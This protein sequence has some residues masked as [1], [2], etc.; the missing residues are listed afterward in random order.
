[1]ARELASWGRYPYIPQQRHPCSWRND[2]SSLLQRLA[3]HPQGTLPYGN[4]RSYGDSCLAVSGELLQTRQL[5]RFLSAD[6][7]Q[8]VIR[9]EAGVTLAEVLEVAI[10][11]GWFLPVTP[12]TKFVTLGGA[13]ANDVH[14]KN[15]HVRG[16]FGCHVRCFALQ[17]SDLTEPLACSARDNSELFHASIGGLGLT[18]VIAW[19]EL[20]LMPIASSQIDSITVR[21]DSLAEFF[22]LS[23]EFDRTHEYTVAWI[24]CLAKGSRAGRG[25]F[26]VGNHVREGRLNVHERTRL[27]VPLTPPV[28]LM[29]Q[30]SLNLFNNTYFHLHKPGRNAGQGSYDPFFYPLDSILHWNR[31]YGSKGFQQYQCVIPNAAAEAAMAEIL[32][33]IAESG[34]GS[35]L[36]VMKRCGDMPS[37]GL[38]SFPM[39]G[40]SLALDFPQHAK[41]ESALFHRLDQIVRSAG[42]RLY[43]AK[44][45]HMTGDDFRMFY[46]AWQQVEALRDPALLSHFWKRVTQA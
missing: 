9:A 38:M 35:F 26:S 29:N 41:L 22:S 6:W 10:P 36:A 3:S 2:L 13:V 8:G 24:D 19:V 39:P 7:E 46:P 34:S 18:G 44:D 30:L 15:H 45:A 25:I 14:G 31:I 33:S 23:E 17:R 16:T 32:A 5:D 27:S 28:T 11:H 40:V 21:F 43:P 37:P 1:M 4:G 20:Q 42:G 12:G